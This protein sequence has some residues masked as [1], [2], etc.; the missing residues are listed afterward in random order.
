VSGIIARTIVDQHGDSAHF[1]IC[2]NEGAIGLSGLSGED[3][4]EALGTSLV[5][6]KTA[7]YR[8]PAAVIDRELEAPELR[9][10]VIRYF[11]YVLSESMMTTF[12]NKHH[13]LHQQFCRLLLMV[14]DR[15]TSN[16]I[17]TT[18]EIVAQLLGSRREGITEAVGRL[19]KEKV[20]THSRGILRIA[21]RNALLQRTCECYFRLHSR[22]SSLVGSDARERSDSASERECISVRPA[23][24]QRCVTHSR[25]SWHRCVWDRSDARIECKAGRQPSD[26]NATARSTI[27]HGSE[28]GV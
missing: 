17:R 21:D 2:G 10:L 23:M 13:T 15:T 27:G 28:R 14:S 11:R 24:K 9:W 16:D 6:V 8:C 18:H 3:P 26:Y 20:V 19:R 4:T 7:A 25:Y 12:C 22:Y 5:I 1:G